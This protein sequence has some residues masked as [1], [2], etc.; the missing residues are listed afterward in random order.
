MNIKALL[1]VFSIFCSAIFPFRLAFAQDCTVTKEAILKLRS[2]V[3]TSS[4]V[5]EYSIGDEGYENF[6]GI[7]PAHINENENES[8]VLAGHYTEKDK[9]VYRPFFVKIDNRGKQVWQ[10]KRPNISNQAIVQFI[11]T[12]TGYIALSNIKKSKKGT[13]IA[14]T[15]LNKNGDIARDKHIF[16]SG[17][18]IAATDITLAQNK[19]SFL[20]TAHTLG[21]KSETILYQVNSKGN[22]Q[23]KRRYRPG[24]E[25]SFQSIKATNNDSYIVSGR[26]EQE[27]GREAGWLLEL[28]PNGAIL[29]QRQFPRGKNATLNE[30]HS[31][32][33][34][35]KQPQSGYIA[36][37]YATPTDGGHK[38]I[39]IV[40]TDETGNIQWQ[41]YYQ[42]NTK[43]S[44]GNLIRNNDG[45]YRLLLG[46]TPAKKKKGEL[47]VRPYAKILTLSP[48][49]YLMDV[50]SHT[51]DEG[52]HP[53]IMTQSKNG[54]LV[55]TGRIQ[56][57]VPNTNDG[58]LS[59]SLYDGWFFSTVASDPYED[60]C[61]P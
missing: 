50:E 1:I 57:S 19:K 18:K 25:N 29:W 31:I 51:S 53:T 43:L 24:L 4:T 22:I 10:K 35:K 39:W 11:K 45:L 7:V 5:W 13:G 59:P 23:W 52:I 8:F 60:P 26:I 38:G 2:P 14:L 12:K 36:L 58:T 32:K 21:E 6:V 33:G 61:V 44:A 55:I 41:R 28:D 42:G 27:D 16:Q 46:A 37:G 15:F 30:V 49:G 9:E 17:E 54:Q 40:K 20:I 48:R 34:N 3:F 56:R 47:S